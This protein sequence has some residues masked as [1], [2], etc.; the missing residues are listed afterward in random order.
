MKLNKVKGK[1][2]HYLSKDNTI[3]SNKENGG[4]PDSLGR[5]AI[6]LLVYSNVGE[7]LDGIKQYYIS[8][9]DELSVY[10][11][12]DS[13]EL[14]SRDHFVLATACT[15]LIGDYTLTTLG[16][17]N[18]VITKPKLTLTQ[19]LWLRSLVRRR[20]PWLYVGLQH[21][22]NKV[23]QG[24]NWFIKG[25]GDKMFT[26]SG[27]RKFL[28]SISFPTYAAYYT[29]FMIQC[30]ED[31]KLRK[32]LMQS[33]KPLFERDNYVARALAGQNMITK[34]VIEEYE[35][36]RKNRWST[37]LDWLGDRDMTKYPEDKKGGLNLEYDLLLRIY[38]GPIEQIKD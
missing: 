21:M 24:W 30:I 12:H 10:R 28:R 9:D 36:T 27:A 7:L 22:A 18:K 35:P 5:T 4:K 25:L 34:E 38:E 2:C 17:E 32:F 23:Y 26:R 16:N 37:R 6:G 3:L 1:G 14:N 20:K 33:I 29:L 19:R 13:N 31:D 8:T 15:N 11:Y